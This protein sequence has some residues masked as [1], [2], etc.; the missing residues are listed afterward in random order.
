MLKRVLD[1]KQ[2]LSEAKSHYDTSYNSLMTTVRDVIDKM[3]N[4]KQYDNSVGASL[5]EQAY[6]RLY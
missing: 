3:I 5:V 4:D 6:K 1:L 2:Q